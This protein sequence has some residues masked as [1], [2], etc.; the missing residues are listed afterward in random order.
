MLETDVHNPNRLDFDSEAL[1]DAWLAL[2]QAAERHEFG[3]AVALIARHGQIVLHRA[4]GWA[5]REPEDERSPMGVD[6][7]FDLA[8]LT[9]VTATTPSILKLVGEGAF[10]LD[11]PVR[12]LLPVMREAGLKSPMTIGHL[13]THSAGLVSWLPVF[14]TD[15][16]PEA[17]LRGFAR[18]GVI[19]VPGE[20]VVY[21][22]PSFITLGEVVREVS[23]RSVAGY[24]RE[25]IFEPLGMVDTM[26]TPPKALTLRIAATELGNDFEADK[27]PGQQPAVGPWRNE[28]LRGEVHDGNACYGFNGVAGHAGLFGTAIDLFRYGQMWLH[29]GALDDVSILPGALVEEATR[30]QIEDQGERRGLG[31]R[32]PPCL[33]PDKTD[34]ARGVGLRGFGHTGFTGTSLWMDPDAGIVVVLLTNRVHPTVKPDYMTTRGDF[35]EQVMGAAH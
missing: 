14:V 31:W 20:R 6:T 32:L 18:H 25:H 15:S 1:E 9:K 3:G 4:T 23:G 19:E 2:V 27:L 29:G 26:F 24:A 17:Y 21:S 11:T 7:I 28:L 35:M 8:S 30:E 22:D 16:G 5:V 13:L 33:K 10:A 34:S 12:D